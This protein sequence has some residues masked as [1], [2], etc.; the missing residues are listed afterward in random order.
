MKTAIVTLVTPNIEEYA[1][2]TKK[3]NSEY[4][5]E[6]GYDFFVESERLSDRSPQWDKV[7]IAEKYIDDYDLIFWIDADAMITRFDVKIE[8]FLEDGKWFF[9]CDDTPN[10][11]YKCQQS[12]TLNTGG[13]LLDTRGR[14]PLI[15]RFVKRW[16]HLGELL[17]LQHR[18]WHEQTAINIL[19]FEL[20]EFNIDDMKIY[21][22]DAFNSQFAPQNTH[23][24]KKFVLHA[25]GSSLKVRVELITK[26]MEKLNLTLEDK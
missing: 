18:C 7:A 14:K 9:I 10:R 1:K 2:Y 22:V 15:K 19:V 4:C 5:K 12:Y 8:E 21:P 24:E 16:W 3:V 25:L 20:H 6:R 13:F 26:W 11:G 17:N 23:R